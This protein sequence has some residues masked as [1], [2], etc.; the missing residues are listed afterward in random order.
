MP[1]KYDSEDT[2]PSGGGF[3]KNAGRYKVRVE[4]VENK[5]AKGSGN[6]MIEVTLADVDSG[7][8]VVDRLIDIESCHWKWAT[9]A[10]ACGV[11]I[12]R[13][14]ELV[15]DDSWVG[16]TLEI[17][18]KMVPGDKRDFAEV[19]KHIFDPNVSLFSDSAKPKAA[20]KAT[21]PDDEEGWD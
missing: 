16:K 13:N 4:K 21:E 6:P 14:Q 8:H 11:Q 9:F 2:I 17:E 18:V 1:F 10:K 12:A 20:P 19:E 5:I 15:I 3:I 7:D